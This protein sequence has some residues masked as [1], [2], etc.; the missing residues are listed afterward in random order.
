M[1]PAAGRLRSPVITANI[2]LING[3][4]G[5]LAFGCHGKGSMGTV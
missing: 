5:D 3:A 4:K 2:L 1:W